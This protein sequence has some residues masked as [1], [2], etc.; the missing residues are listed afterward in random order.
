M[1]W[2]GSWKPS[3][4]TRCHGSILCI[5]GSQVDPDLARR[6]LRVCHLHHTRGGGSSRWEAA[7]QLDHQWLEAQDPVGQAPTSK[8]TGRHRRRS[9]ASHCLPDGSCTP[10]SP[11]AVHGSLSS[12]E[13][14]A[15]TTGQTSSSSSSRSWDAKTSL[16]FHGPIISWNATRSSATTSSWKASAK[17]VKAALLGGLGFHLISLLCPLLSPALLVGTTWKEVPVHQDLLAL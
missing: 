8:R 16:P 3:H 5:R 11:N 4:G 17:E 15:S 7:R 10:G 13:S 2:S 12:V 1:G 14:A 9:S 6:Q